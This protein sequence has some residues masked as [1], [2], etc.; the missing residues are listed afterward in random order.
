MWCSNACARCVLKFICCFGRL[1]M[2]CSWLQ[3]VE[4]LGHIHANSP[5]VHVGNSE[6]CQG[7][8]EYKTADRVVPSSI[9]S[10]MS[11]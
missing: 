7:L 6:H 11:C 3:S 9:L 10:G 1:M 5:H 4:S 2:M 8:T